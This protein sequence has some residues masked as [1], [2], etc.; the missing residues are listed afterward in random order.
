MALGEITFKALQPDSQ[1]GPEVQTKLALLENWYLQQKQVLSAISGGVDSCLA[2]FLG[3][4]F[5]GKENAIG[6]IS[7][8]ESLKSADFEIA[9]GFCRDHDITLEV[10][11]TNE[12]DDPNYLTNPIN[13]CYF[14][15][16]SLYLHLHALIDTRYAGFKIINGNNASDL[17]DYRPGMQAADEQSI[18][19][20]FVAC[21]VTK[22]DIREIAYFYNLKVWN[23]PASP[24]LSS[25][26]P[27][28]Q[29]ITRESLSQ[30][31]QAE[32]VLNNYGF[33]E[34]R[35]RNFNNTAKIEVPTDF[36]TALRTKFAQINEEILQLGFTSCTIDNEGLIS[37]KLNK[38]I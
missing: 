1:L 11:K 6:V 21:G 16:S 15:K 7:N 2:S 31:E 25:R 33:D 18:L 34:V 36:L 9:C 24:C 13:R 12:L 38:L 17:S 28:G 20:P 19:S 29:A 32:K 22:N 8:S 27:Y 23:K 5:L 30:V 10:I 14:C 4:K 26:F 3:R 35:V 37:G